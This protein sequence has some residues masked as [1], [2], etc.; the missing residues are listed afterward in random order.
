MTSAGVRGIPLLLAERVGVSVPLLTLVSVV[1]IVGPL[2][3]VV[4]RHAR[5]TLAA[6][7]GA[8][9]AESARATSPPP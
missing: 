9:S 4:L 2:A 1:V 5:A 7:R 8:M 6:T 3:V